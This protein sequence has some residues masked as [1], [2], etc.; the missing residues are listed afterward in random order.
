MR[1]NLYTGTNIHKGEPMKL[2]IS[3]A[4]LLLLI[5]ASCSKSPMEIPLTSENY[6]TTVEQI[7]K[8]ADSDTWDAVNGMILLANIFSDSGTSEKLPPEWEGKTF[9]QLLEAASEAFNDT[10]T[11]SSV[12]QASINE[13]IDNSIRL[14]EVHV[15]S[16]ANG[17]PDTWEID[18][19]FTNVGD[20]GVTEYIAD[21]SLVD[22]DGIEYTR[23]GIS[24]KPTNGVL[25]P[26]ERDKV[27]YTLVESKG[28]EVV[29]A[30][31]S[32]EHDFTLNLLGREAV[33]VNSGKYTY[34]EE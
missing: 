19:D 2:R 9:N 10:G 5:L 4:L 33:F 24:Y 25:N 29:S 7:R 27:T 21:L 26:G 8:T 17:D 23:H 12:D 11:E 34:V 1:L 6:Q 28:S 20:E 32:G 3:I 15:F 31:F 22:A 14:A 16:A 18:V 30:L 13:K